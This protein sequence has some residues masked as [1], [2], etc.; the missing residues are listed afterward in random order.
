VPTLG[1]SG[2]LHTEFHRD[3]WFRLLPLLHI[4]QAASGWTFGPHRACV[5]FDDPNLHWPSYGYVDFKELAK[6]AEDRN[7]H[8]AFATVPMDAW[9]VS[10]RA[11]G[12]F[13]KHHSRLSLAIHGNDHTHRELCQERSEKDAVALAFHALRRA[14]RLERLAGV[15]VDRIMAAPHGACSAGMAVALLRAG[16]EAACISRGS[17][18]NRNPEVAFPASVGL[19]PAEFIGGGFPII[20]RFGLHSDV[21]LQSRLALSLGQPAIAVGHHDELSDGLDSVQRIASVCNSVGAVRWS[22]LSA[23]ARANY[24]TKSDRTALRV[25]MFGRTAVVRVPPGVT[26]IILERAWLGTGDVEGVTV[27]DAAKRVSGE[28]K[29]GGQVLAVPVPSGGTVNVQS[30]LSDRIDPVG[31]ATRWSRPA[32]IIRRQ[33]CE[34]RDRVRPVVDRFRGRSR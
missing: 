7:Y 18:M 4:V 21:E 24:W 12:L 23:I 16:F 8:C 28:V 5:M 6:D 31:A 22:R 32:A 26:S 20:P 3:R 34:V 14:D 11:A 2:F 19:G 30:V 33:G 25:R 9:F 13:Q 17:L 27:E 29:Y 1:Q 15:P 10:S